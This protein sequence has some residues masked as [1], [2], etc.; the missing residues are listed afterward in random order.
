M[1]KNKPEGFEALQIR[2][3]GQVAR[4]EE[5]ARRVTEL[6]DGKVEQI[7]ELDAV[8]EKPRGGVRANYRNLAS[9]SVIL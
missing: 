8:P 7:P 6:L 2:L 5:L 3:A 1:R 4:H 9:G